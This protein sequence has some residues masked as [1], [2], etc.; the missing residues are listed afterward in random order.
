MLKSREALRLYSHMYLN[1]DYKSLKQV[2]G[3]KQEK[4]TEFG[5]KKVLELV[6]CKT[7]Q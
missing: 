1:P 2:R 7:G 5:C 6:T 3:G 4:H